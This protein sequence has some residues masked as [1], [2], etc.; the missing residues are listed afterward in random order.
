M[1]C[2]CG[3]RSARSAAGQQ[4][5]AGQRQRPSTQYEATYSDGSTQLFDTEQEVMAALSFK[6]GGYRAVVAAS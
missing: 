5:Q 3:N 2:A 6:G 4:Q 1:A